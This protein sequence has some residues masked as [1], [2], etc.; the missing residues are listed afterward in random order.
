MQKAERRGFQVVSLPA[1]D[2]ERR[3]RRPQVG[4]E[5]PFL[6]EKMSLGLLYYYTKGNHNLMASY[7]LK[8]IRWFNFGVNYTF[9]GPARTF[10][11][12]IEFI[13]KKVVGLFAGANVASFKTNSWGIPIKNL[14]ES[15]CFGLNVVFGGR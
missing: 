1:I 9:L 12:Y 5:A 10:G 7:N 14:T 2:V 4:A 11:L 13:P 6:Q 15:A 3:L 8:P